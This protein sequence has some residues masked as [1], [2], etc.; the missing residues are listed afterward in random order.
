MFDK[1]A[2]HCSRESASDMMGNTKTGAVLSEIRGWSWGSMCS[3]GQLSAKAVM[4]KSGRFRGKLAAQDDCDEHK[5]A[6]PHEK[7]KRSEGWLLP[8]VVQD[9]QSS[10]GV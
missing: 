8:L 2:D 9:R 6:L 10:L 3:S 5:T 4:L 7:M 1:Q